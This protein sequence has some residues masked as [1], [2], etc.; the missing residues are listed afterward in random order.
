M[1]R[2]NHNTYCHFAICQ[3]VRDI[4]A[5]HQEREQHCVGDD[6][7][8]HGAEM[9]EDSCTRGTSLSL[10]SLVDEDRDDKDVDGADR[11]GF[12]R[13]KQAGVDAADGD[14]DQQQ[15]R[16]RMRLAR[17][18]SAPAEGHLG[19]AVGKEPHRRH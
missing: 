19:R 5:S 16:D 9:A 8:K 1:A 12:R 17:R 10:K 6:V 2:C 18:L 15:S 4:L 11:R 7:E 14:D 3:R 13:R